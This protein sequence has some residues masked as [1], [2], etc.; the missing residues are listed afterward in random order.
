[1]LSVSVVVPVRNAV[2]TL[3]HCLEALERLDPQPLEVVLVNNG[4]TDGSQELLRAFSRRHTPEGA[5][6]VEEP[7]PGIS[8]ARNAGIRQARGEILAW[9]DSDC[10]PDPA[11]LRYLIEPF[12]ESRVGAVAG[13]VLP[14]PAASVVELFCGLYTFI[15]PSHRTCHVRWTPWTGGYAGANFAVRRSLLEELGGYDETIAYGGDDYDLCARLYS[16]R[17][18]IAYA[19]K[20]QVVHFHRATLPGMLHQAFG[21]GRSHPY[22]LRRH[23]TSGLWLDI[24]RF[25]VAWPACPVRAWVDLASADKKVLAILILG[26]LSPLWLLALPFY[27]VWLAVGT[28]RRA[29]QAGTPVSAASAM[30]LA[31][32]LLLKSAAMT[33]GRWWGSV[34]YGAFCL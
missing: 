9:T 31:G 22:L 10:A 27:G 26:A 8:L 32:M 6:V 3:P 19:P 21:F 12:A 20:A 24:P 4:S 13:R 28:S 15:T 1:M 33:A 14:A 7:R 16:R 34:K 30:A 5:Q 11:W 29:R 2:K 25:S 17:H 18:S 23:M